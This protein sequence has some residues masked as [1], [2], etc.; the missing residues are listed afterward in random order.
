MSGA[1]FDEKSNVFIASISIDKEKYILCYADLS[2]GETH[3]MNL[4]FNEELLQ[5]EIIKLNIKELVVSED[6][7]YIYLP[8]LKNTLGITISYES[9]DSTIDYLKNL[10]EGLDKAEEKTF[11]RLLNYLIKTQKRVLL[12]LQ[13]V[14]K[15]SS[16]NFLK[17]D[18]SSRRNLEL[19]ETLRFQNKKNTLLNVL[20]KCQ[21]AMGSRYLKQ[22][23]MFPLVSINEINQRY[24]VIELFKKNFIET[25]EIRDL[26]SSIYDLE[27]I[28]GKIA[29]ESAN[30]RDYFN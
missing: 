11:Y 17:I 13:K 24:D 12:H 8:Y 1:N 19:L 28:S 25:L 20:D 6:F 10:S 16:T 5:T 30:P 22:S 29:Y 15:I 9:N 27:R 18:F 7:N 4:P 2:T 26:L 23:I 14:N 3:L 21:T